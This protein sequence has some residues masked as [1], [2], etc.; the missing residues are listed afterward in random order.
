M[1]KL[2]V[3]N[4]VSV[5]GYFAGPNGEID[6]H[7]IDGEFNQFSISQLQEVGALLFGRVTYD[8]MASYWPQASALRDDPVVA[9]AMNNLPKV[10]FSKTM[11]QV[12]WN[13]TKLMKEINPEEIRKMKNESGKDLFIFGSG[14]IVRAFTDLGLINEFR[15]M[16]NPVILG[17]GRGLFQ[18]IKKKMTLKLIKTKTFGSGNILLYYQTTKEHRREQ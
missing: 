2:I 18:D 8:L 7:N 9:N 3:F 15:L 5:D 11:N 4:M 16:V 13:N 17:R 10:V 1:R 14:T 12:G 6:W